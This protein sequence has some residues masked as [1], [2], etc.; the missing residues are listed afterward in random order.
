MEALDGRKLEHLWNVEHLR[1]YYQYR[2]LVKKVGINE[3]K[4]CQQFLVVY[5]LS[6]STYVFQ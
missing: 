1:K 3:H 2:R 4:D 5:L 6:F